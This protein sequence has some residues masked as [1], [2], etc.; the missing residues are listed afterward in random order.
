MKPAAPRAVF[1]IKLLRP[2]LL[3]SCINKFLSN[4]GVYGRCYKRETAFLRYVNREAMSACI[5]ESMQAFFKNIENMLL[6]INAFNPR[7][8]LPEE[9][10][11]GPLKPAT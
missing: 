10:H 8:S 5:P 3:F 4:S 2:L 1:L 9:P 7:F 6:R 11:E